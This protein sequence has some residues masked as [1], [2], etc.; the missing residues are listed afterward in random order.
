MAMLLLRN[1]NSNDTS[2]QFREFPRRQIAQQEKGAPDERQMLS[3]SPAA[4]CWGRP[5]D[6]AADEN[7]IQRRAARSTTT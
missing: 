6:D 5:L 7:Q 3:T 4:R 1:K 2:E